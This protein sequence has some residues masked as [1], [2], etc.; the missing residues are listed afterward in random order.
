MGEKTYDDEQQPTIVSESSQTLPPILREPIYPIQEF[1]N[2]V[3]EQGSGVEFPPS[4]SEP[5]RPEF[6]IRDTPG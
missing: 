4:L 2:T 3:G 1:A 6:R 5:V